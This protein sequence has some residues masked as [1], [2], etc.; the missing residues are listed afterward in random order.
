MSGDDSATTSGKENDV[1]LE[2]NQ[3][4]LKINLAQTGETAGNYK[5][6]DI[7][8]EFE[9][10]EGEELAKT[11]KS[12]Y[13]TGRQLWYDHTTLLKTLEW[14][15]D[16][17]KQT[18]DMNIPRKSMRGV[19][20][21]FTKK[22]PTDSEEFLNAN[23]ERVSVSVEGNP[24][25]V[26]SKGLTKS[27]IYNEARRFFGKA[28]DVNN[29]NL[30]KLKFLKDKYALVGLSECSPEYSSKSINS[31]RASTFFATSLLSLMEVFR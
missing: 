8:F 25:S 17:E 16:S 1:L 6:T 11:V 3:K 2:K 30:S 13:Q 19:V 26:Y 9:T 28:K 4:F 12:D 22:N 24:N 5:L 29:D 7:S 27:E 23:I 18:I 10:I 14:K 21:L 15:K 20:L 31:Q